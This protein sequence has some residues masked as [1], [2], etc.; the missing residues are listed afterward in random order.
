VNRRLE[1]YLNLGM[2]FK[3]SISDLLHRPLEIIVIHL[4]LIQGGHTKKPECWPNYSIERERLKQANVY[5][6]FVTK[7]KSYEEN[8][9]FIVIPNDCSYPVLQFQ[10]ISTQ[11]ISMIRGS[12]ASLIS[13]VNVHHPFSPRSP[14]VLSLNLKKHRNPRMFL[15]QRWDKSLIHKHHP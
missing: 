6:R 1:E 9:G 3:P 5:A 13:S 7:K 15:F 11:P 2:M 10:N 4:R 12:C 14:N 8:H